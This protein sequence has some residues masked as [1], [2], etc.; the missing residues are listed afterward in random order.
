MNKDNLR[1]FASVAYGISAGLTFGFLGGF[2]IGY[3]NPVAPIV[4]LA[5]AIGAFVAGKKLSEL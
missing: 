2:A 1:Q 3:P 4:V 5:L